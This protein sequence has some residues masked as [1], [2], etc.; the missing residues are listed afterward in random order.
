MVRVV[1]WQDELRVKMVQSAKESNERMRAKWGGLS[2]EKQGAQQKKP[3]P[4]APPKLP[5]QATTVN[6]LLLKG[7]TQMEIADVLG[8]SRQAVNRTVLRHNLPR[9]EGQS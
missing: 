4:K 8:V 5:A 6:K 7:F 1:D 2:W 3:E 9:S